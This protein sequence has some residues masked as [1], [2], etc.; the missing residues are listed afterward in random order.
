LKG[1][2]GERIQFTS[3]SS[4]ITE[5]ENTTAIR[6]IHAALSEEDP[7][8][9]LPNINANIQRFNLRAFFKEPV[10]ALGLIYKVPRF[11]FIRVSA[12]LL[13]AQTV[14]ASLMTI[15]EMD[16]P[17]V[18]FVARLF[19]LSCAFVILVGRVMVND[20]FKVTAGYFFLDNA[21]L[22]I[23]Y[24]RW[25]VFRKV[26]FPALGATVISS[27]VFFY[28]YGLGDSFYA[29]GFVKL[30]HQIM[31]LIPA[32]ENLFMNSS[33]LSVM[34]VIGSGLSTI[35][36]VSS[37]FFYFTSGFLSLVEKFKKLCSCNKADQKK[38]IIY[39]LREKILIGFTIA[40]TILDGLAFGATTFL[41]AMN[42]GLVN[43]TTNLF[44]YIREGLGNQYPTFCLILGAGN[45][46]QNGIFGL[47]SA[48]DAIRSF[49]LGFRN[50]KINNYP[51][52]EAQVGDSQSDVPV[53]QSSSSDGE[54]GVN[55][56]R[57]NFVNNN[58]E[59]SSGGPGLF[60]KARKNE[61]RY[62]PSILSSCVIC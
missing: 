14:F 18:S 33:F 23:R 3:D 41:F 24:W 5:E 49:Q 58:N 8:L 60:Q 52:Q 4:I 34:G 45:A 11:I 22:R 10:T 46:A 28:G 6:V 13:M 20:A 42:S 25:P 55:L 16:R 39:T 35:L 56:S 31:W 15:F 51:S 7:D 48:V 57:H 21:I 43:R 1:I 36:P 53:D 30:G 2:H 17:D 19:A 47:K 32:S 26:I 37:G 61:S 9:E 54:G 62:C 59:R 40:A 44:W 12:N 38:E 29:T 50:L 27:L